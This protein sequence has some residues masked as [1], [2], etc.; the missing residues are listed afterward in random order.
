MK[1]DALLHFVPTVKVA[2]PLTADISSIC[3]DSRRVQP[4]SC[5]VALR[6]EK[7]DGALFIRD[8]IE[9][10]ATAVIAESEEPHSRATMI[11]VKNAR[12]ALADVAANF[13]QHPSKALK[14][15][16]V[17]GTNG[18]TTVTFLLKHIC[19]TALLR[20]GVIGTVRYEIGERILPAT[21]TTPESL[22]LQDLL[23]QMRS[24]GC[25]AAAM[26][27]SSHALDQARVRNVEFD[28]A[29]FTNLS[30]D[31]LDFHKTMEAYAEAKS[32]LFS[33]LT[34]QTKKA[35]GIFNID[36]R[37]GSQFALRFGR[38]M[39][40]IGYGC[41]VKADFRASNIRSDLNGT[42][43]Q[44]D[45]NG[46]SYLV[47]LPMIG[48]FNVYNSLAAIAGAHVMG[49]EVRNAVLV[50]ANAPAVPGRLQA[51]PGQR[52]FRV[53]VDYA[54]TDDALLNVVKTCRDL[55]P[56][57][58]I[59]VFG[60]GGNR[61]RSKRPRMGAV[62]DSHADWAIVTSDNPRKEDPLAIIE[63]IK[64]GMARGNYEVIVNRDEAI[65]K[66]IAMAQP[67]DIVLIAGKGHETYQE[68]ADHTVPFDD[69]AVASRAIEGKRIEM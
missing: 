43:Y 33:G 65:F 32:R 4:G 8:A 63:D 53:I 11:V 1:L 58:L 48:Q 16:G 49:V 9:K 45:A 6:G 44:L 68:F 67:R 3:Y 41:G 36:D 52:Q 55:N 20:C 14:I 12:L 10:G 56:A 25:K 42:S 59:V 57:R 24:A 40:V 26:E 69:V 28:T 34:A 18:K 51:V 29:I 62:V 54:H 21:R 22:D 27:V 30:Q 64:P 38:E 60:C 5:F 47:R 39:P 50:L 61:D 66:A 19:E 7:S 2:G 37:C 31:H 13:Y 17:T 23:W 35:K 46:R 15:A